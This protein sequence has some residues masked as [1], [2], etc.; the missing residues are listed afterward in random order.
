MGK[1]RNSWIRIFLCWIVALSVPGAALTAFAGTDCAR[2][3]DAAIKLFRTAVSPNRANTKGRGYRVT[4]IHWDPVLRQSWA[5]IANCDHP[6]WPEVSVRAEATK[7]GST[8]QMSHDGAESFPFVPVIHAGDIVR[9]WRQEDLMRIE[10][11]G[12]AEESG[13]IGKTIR[14][15]LLRRKTDDQ[16]KEEQF[17]GIIRGPSDVE[18]LR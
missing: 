1:N 7:A 6:E 14:V 15:R 4:S 3:P 5:R 18:M 2:T 10:I 17:T 11:T 9:L 12:V 8:R 16:A 13:G